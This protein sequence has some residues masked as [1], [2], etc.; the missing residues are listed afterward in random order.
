MSDN[1]AWHDVGEPDD[2]S[3]EAAWP[4]V[5]GGK[6]I[7][8][9]RQGDEIFAL[10]DLCTHGAAQLSDG[11]VE[12]GQVECPLHQGTFDLRTGAACKAP[13]VEP[14]RTFAVRLVAGRVEVEV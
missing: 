6:A 4:V 5:A 9:F 12:D 10:H 11:W 3:E 8:M 14:V 7:A 13:C 2:F 1:T